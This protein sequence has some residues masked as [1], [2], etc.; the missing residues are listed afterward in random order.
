MKETGFIECC[1]VAGFDN[2]CRG[3]QICDVLV[4]SGVTEEDA[5]KVMAVKFA[6]AVTQLFDTHT[7][8]KCSEV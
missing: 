6:L 2:A 7:R 1:V 8:A 4:G 3:V 5:G